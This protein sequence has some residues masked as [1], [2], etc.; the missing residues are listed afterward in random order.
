MEKEQYRSVIRFLF[1]DGKTCEEIKVKLHAVYKDHA[2]SMT[3]IRYWF[4][5]FKRG[6]TSVFDEERPGRPIE[7]ST[8]DMVNKIHD[9]VLADRRV[10]IREI[11]DIVNISIER[12]QNILH[13]KLGMKK[14]SARWVPR[15]LTVEQK[16]NRMTTSEHCLAMFKRNPKEFLRRFVTVDETWIHHYTP[17][18]KEQSKQWTS[19]GEPAPKKAKTVPSAGKVMATVFWDSGGIIFTD[20]LEKGRTITGQYYADLL[21]RFH[22]ELMRKRA[23]LAKKK[24]LFHHDNAP[25]HSSSIARAKLVELRYEL[26]PHPPYSPD[27]A[28]CDFFL[29][30]NMKK[31]LGGK[32]F[33]SNEEV[34][35]Q[36]EAYFE[37]FDKSYFLDGLK[38]LEHR[39]TKCIELRGDYVEK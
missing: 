31:W 34:I 36:T 26:L 33:T 8:E 6:R 21:G 3:T 16:R 30:P 10:K 32:R 4:N 38:K 29:F 28:P 5:E 37:E 20:Y 39:W 2:P 17:E 18:M 27:L 14:L 19:P 1:L 24:V 15:L 13:E 9:V 22:P 7:V 35:D 12:V 23:H 25:A 11:A